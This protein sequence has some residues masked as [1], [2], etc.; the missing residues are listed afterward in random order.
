M[1]YGSDAASFE[2]DTRPC[3]CRACENHRRYQRLHPERHKEQ[4][5]AYYGRNQEKI[6]LQKAY[7]RYIAGHTK[8]FHEQ[9]LVR[10]KKAG[11]SIPPDTT[12]RFTKEDGL[13]GDIPSYI[14]AEA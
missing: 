3:P 6:L 5:R 12:S 7:A 8:K 2:N 10:L 13:S 1:V 11:F 9:T 4:V 14:S